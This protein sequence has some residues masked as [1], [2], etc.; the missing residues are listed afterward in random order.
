MDYYDLLAPQQ[1]QQLARI[2]PAGQAASLMLVH[3]VPGF[4]EL[5]AE[6]VHEQYHADRLFASIDTVPGYIAASIL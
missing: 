5:D 1:E 2:R 3:P 4:T 6:E